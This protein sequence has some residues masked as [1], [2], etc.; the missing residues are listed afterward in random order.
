MKRFQEKRKCSSV[1]R[2]A[3]LALAV[4]AT[5]ILGGC[6]LTPVYGDAAARSALALNYAEPDNRLEQIVY[7]TLSARL[8]GG[9][10]AAPLFSASVSA[11]ASRLG[12]S[13][14]AS[15]LTDYLV[16]ATIDYRVTRDGTVLT[17]GR[18]TATATYQTTDQYLADDAARISA[19]EQAVRAAAETV[20]LA[21]I[22]ALAPQ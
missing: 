4:S 8:G 17:S 1:L 16:T 10:A 13:E 19:N 2:A 20:R 22:A 7:Q 5:V 6:S 15:P 3:A 14:V 21:L 18:R 11:S 12:V 9:D